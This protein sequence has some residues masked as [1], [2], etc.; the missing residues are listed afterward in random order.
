MALYL[1]KTDIGA[2]LTTWVYCAMWQLWAAEKMGRKGFI[3]WPDDPLRSL[4]PYRDPVAFAGSPNMFDW[5]FKQPLFD[6]PPERTETWTWEYNPEAGQHNFMSQPLDVIKAYY[7]E[8][9]R[10]SDA[11]EARGRALA[12]K[13]A[14]DF[15]NTLAVTWR[16]T[17]CVTDGRP[18]L[19]I[20]VYFPFIDEI[21]SEHPGLRIFATAEEEGVL[22]ALLLRYPQAFTITE[23]YSA[24]NGSLQNPERFSPFSGYERGMQPALLV[25]LLSKCAHYVK[26]RSSMGGVASW[27]S[28]GNIVCLAHPENLGYGFDITKAEIKGQIVPL[29]R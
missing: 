24:P 9:C 22:D 7:R 13:Y 8:H 4:E 12:E 17:D 6:A 15:G 16:G 20:E 11:V 1:E 25:W 19:P 27:L 5:Y 2:T 29:Y 23:F 10:F 28:T 3:H 14:I 18:R 26:N 21:I